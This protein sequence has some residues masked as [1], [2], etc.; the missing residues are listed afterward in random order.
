MYTTIPYINPIPLP[1][2]SAGCWLNYTNNNTMWYTTY[3]PSDHGGYSYKTPLQFPFRPQ[4]VEMMPAQATIEPCT[5]PN[6]LA[7][8]LATVL[9]ETFDIEPMGR[10]HVY[11]KLYTDYYIHLPYSIVYRVLEFSK[12]SGDDGKTTLEHVGQFIL[13]CGEATTNDAL[14]FRIFP[15]SLSDTVFT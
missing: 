10:G 1:G 13:Q 4:T 14:K 6:N 12:F 3:G 2:S 11:Q 15:L 8:Q 7:T 9:R 5:D